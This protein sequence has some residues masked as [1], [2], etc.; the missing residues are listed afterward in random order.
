MVV[1][2]V[3]KVVALTNSGDAISPSLTRV[4]R[5]ATVKDSILVLKMGKL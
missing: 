3:L 4:N 2:L 1:E 5:L